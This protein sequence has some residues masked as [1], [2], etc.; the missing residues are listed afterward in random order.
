MGLVPFTVRLLALRHEFV[1]LRWHVLASR[2]EKKVGTAL[3]ALCPT[4]TL[5][6]RMSVLLARSW[7]D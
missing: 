7:I 2:C 6:D 1:I 5:L 4:H 3:L